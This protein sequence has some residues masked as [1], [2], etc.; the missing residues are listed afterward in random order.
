M[1]KNYSLLISCI[2]SILAILP[3]HLIAELP[4]DLPIPIMETLDRP[5]S[6]A[7]FLSPFGPSA[8]G[9]PYRNYLMILDTS[10]DVVSYKLVPD[11]ENGYIGYHFKAEP[12][13]YLS[14]LNRK[15]DG[16]IFLIDTNYNVI[17]SYKDTFS[18]YNRVK[19]YAH[20]DL[21]PNGNTQTVLYN[22]KYEDMSKHFPN[23][24]PNGAI[25]Q[26]LIQEL[27]KDNNV[28]FQWKSS[29]YIP[30]SKTQDPPAPNIDYFHPNSMAQDMDG[31]ILIC[32]R[33]LCA[34]YKINRN[35]GEIMWVLGGK[36]NEFKFIGENESNAPNYFSYQHDIR[37]LPNGNITIFDNGR[38]HNPQYS[39]A[40]EY[41]LDQ[42]A[43]TCTMVWEYR[44]EPDYYADQHGSCQRLMNGNTFIAWGT[45]SMNGLTAAT[46]I[47]PDNKVAMEFKFPEGLES[48]FIYRYQWPVCPVIA[49][50]EKSE[51]LELNTY[52]FDTSTDTTGISLKFN[53]LDAF[54]YNRFK[55]VRY[56]CSAMNPSFEGRPPIIMPFRLEISGYDFTSFEVDLQW[57]LDK[58]P[59]MANMENL[60]IYYR[61]EV[62]NGTFIMLETTY[63]SSDNSLNCSINTTGEYIIGFENSPEITPPP[64]VY[65][66]FN[67]SKPN[68]NQPVS[69]EWNPRGY[70]TDNHVQV[71]L[72]TTFNQIIIDTNLR[73]FKMLKSDFS[74]SNK[75]FWRVSS[76]N[77]AGESAW[78]EINSFEMSNPY[79]SMQ[80]P[81]GGEVWDTTAHIIRWDYNL[82]DSV[83]Q[84]FKIELLRNDTLF[85]VLNK[86]RFSAVNAY[87]WTI[88]S[89]IPEDSTYQIRV[90]S[91][92]G[93]EVIGVS[94]NYFTIKNSTT[95]VNESGDD[96]LNITH[97]PNPVSNSVTFNFRTSEFGLTTIMLYDILG[98]EV[99]KIYS[100]MLLP[101]DYSFNWDNITLPSG[102]YIYQISNNGIKLVNKMTIIR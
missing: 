15:L 8:Q 35:T 78:S 27:D 38:Q 68:I 20:Y 85:M 16:T 86:A 44:H 24:E 65:Y 31:N 64:I 7:I 71:A 51:L 81:N 18:L 33:D 10:L 83:D 98:N 93:T 32:A 22:F 99:G 6:E 57:K 73:E 53:Q 70:F 96:K 84:F 17:R 92:G 54:V 14:Y 28:V 2:F 62:G 12:N 46:E 11:Q 88:P 55:V 47:T 69:F 67:G 23:G 21:M 52:K 29:D 75:Y 25:L 72:D 82:R 36:D 13:G 1:S 90:T 101:G 87:K 19:Y 39:R 9:T 66:P 95:G 45:Y 76:S 4:S 50:V 102:N 5:S 80:I 91:I 97:F 94:E 49:S 60:N 40:V 56:D 74:L 30:V 3:L 43:R 61:S 37:V 41:K 79:L 26:A 59:L 48:Q 34:I 100:E 42:D 89:S 77:N 58:Y 63:N